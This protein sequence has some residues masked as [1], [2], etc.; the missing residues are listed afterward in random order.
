LK[1]LDHGVWKTRI[2]EPKQP[3]FSRWR[4]DDKA[5]AAVY[6]NRTRLGSGSASRR[7]GGGRKSSSDPSPTISTAAACAGTWLR[8]RENVHKRYLVHVAGHNLGIL[9]RLL[10]GAGTRERRAARALAYL[11]F[12]YTEEAVSIILIAASPTALPSG[13][14]CYRRPG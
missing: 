7:C 1:S 10:L 12:V 9:M 14:G 5:R 8:G 3:G 4:G 2:A 11:L 13:H 6:A